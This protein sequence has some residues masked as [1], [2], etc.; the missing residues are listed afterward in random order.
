MKHNGATVADATGI[1]QV[2]HRLLKRKVGR[3]GKCMRTALGCTLLGWASFIAIDHFWPTIPGRPLILV[4]ALVFTAGW[5]VHI[6]TFAARAILRTDVAEASEDAVA[7]V[8]MSRRAT[9]HLFG[10]ALAFAVVSSAMLL[11]RSAVGQSQCIQHGLSCTCRGL[12]CCDDDDECCGR[13]PN[14]RCDNF[15]DGC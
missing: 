8:K 11:A 7:T 15:C 12:P 5:I 3:C 6:M 1:W 2:V 13:F 10:R 4:W 9:V 14:T